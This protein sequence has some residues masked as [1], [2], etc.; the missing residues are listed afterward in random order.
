MKKIEIFLFLCCASLVLTDCSD[1]YI[2]PEKVAP[3]K[4]EDGN[5]QI[6][7]SIPDAKDVQVY[8][9][10]TPG[11]NYINECW[12]ITIDG[13]L[14][15]WKGA[16]HITDGSKIVNNGM[17]TALLPQLTFKVDNGDEVYVLC[18]TG[19]TGVNSSSIPNESSINTIRPDKPYYR[20][21]E[22]LPMSGT[23]IWSTSSSSSTVV[24]LTRTV[25]KVQI[26]MGE[27]FNYGGDL[28]WNRFWKW[29]NFQ[30]RECGF[31]VCNYGGMSDIMQSSTLS[32]NISG[33]NPLYGA[34]NGCLRFTQYAATEDSMTI[35]ISEYPNS[36]KDSKGLSITD[37]NTFDKNR[38][39][40]LMIDKVIDG[41]VGDGTIFGVWRLDF[42]DA[43]SKKYLD[44]KRNQTYTFTINKIRSTPY[45][46]F[47]FLSIN[48]LLTCSDCHKAWNFPG[49]NI[50]YEITADDDWAK[51][52][53][54]NGQYGFSVSLDS[55]K[56]VGIAGTEIPFKIKAHIPD[57]VDRSLL[58]R[59]HI[60]IQDRSGGLIGF[61]TYNSIEVLPAIDH[62][63]HRNNGYPF[64][65]DKDTITA[66]NLKVNSYTD[67]DSASLVINLGNVNKIIPI[68]IFP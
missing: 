48:E 43:I 6:R 68:R 10:A 20:G 50:E 32:A 15:N 62:D 52:T 49:S 28:S 45:C 64:R 12:V 55:I 13:T 42:Y 9:T 8:S 35:Y 34:H 61:E 39:F 18:N 37:N 56:G 16:E 19:A 54:S 33:N 40:L 53:Y 30:P 46:T 24:T 17:A 63:Y 25:A 31:V 67:I 66:I 27:S 38:T 26:K 44:I 41:Y 5:S 11:E 14:G 65:I 2:A 59:Y 7:L 57:E 51:A 4:V 22:P 36:I 23:T 29:E 58:Q 1:S 3:E 47:N 21:G 60:S